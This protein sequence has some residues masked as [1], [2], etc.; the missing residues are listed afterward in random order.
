M[1][2]DKGT[3]AW[4]KGNRNNLS[5]IEAE[6]L[7]FLEDFYEKKKPIFTARGFFGP[8]NDSKDGEPSDAYVDDILNPETG[9]TF[10][11]VYGCPLLQKGFF[12]LHI[13]RALRMPK[14]FFS[15]LPRD[16]FRQSK[17]TFF[18]LGLLWFLHR[19]GLLRIFINLFKA[20]NHKVVGV[21]ANWQ[22][23]YY[24]EFEKELADCMLIASRGEGIW[25]E[26]F[27]QAASFIRLFLFADNT[28]KTR[29]QDAFTVSRSLHELINTLRIRELGI[30]RTWKFLDYLF[31][32]MEF[33]SPAF[34]RI[35]KRYF[36]IFD[37]KKIEPD[38]ADRFFSAL[39]KSYNF[40]GLPYWIR[41][42]RWEETVKKYNIRFYI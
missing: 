15:E 41:K 1:E 16:I 11:K 26:L 3:I 40:G 27:K 21:Y 32:I 7:R 17:I 13:V 6:K 8:E 2:S 31:R 38:E 23:S 10:I 34:R 18:F 4:L 37:Y 22:E 36:K 12:D 20:I 9:G 24:N 30:T 19:Q 35:M 29:L 39:Y 25:E 14:H 33:T 5:P 28:Y 42:A